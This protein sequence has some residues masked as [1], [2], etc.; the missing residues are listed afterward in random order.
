MNF[1]TG[2]LYM[3]GFDKIMHT[4]TT[5]PPSFWDSETNDYQVKKL[6]FR[7]CIFQTQNVYIYH[8]HTYW[9]KKSNQSII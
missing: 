6:I 4:D 8:R 2:K 7:L 1:R 3:R 5:P 9:K